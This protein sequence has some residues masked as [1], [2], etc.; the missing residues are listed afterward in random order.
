MYI[1]YKTCV[2][3]GDFVKYAMACFEAVGDKVKNWIMF[4]EPHGFLIEGCDMGLQAL[5]FG[6]TL[7]A[8]A[9]AGE[10]GV[11]FF[12]IFGSEFIKIFV[13]V[14]T[15]QVRDLFKK[16][17]ENAPCIIFIDKLDAVGRQRGA[18]IG[19]HND[20]IEQTLNQLLIEMDGFDRNTG[21]TVPDVNGRKA[22]LKVHAGN[23][24]L[25]KDVSLDVVAMRTPG[26]S[27][28][29]VAGME[30]TAMTDGKSKSLVAY[31]EVGHVIYVTFIPRHDPVK[32]VT[33]VPRGQAQGLT[34]FMPG[35]DPRKISK[36]QIFSRIVGSL[37][38]KAAEEIIFGEPKLKVKLVYCKELDK[39]LDQYSYF[40]V[41]K[42]R[43]LV[44]DVSDIILLD[45]TPLSIGLETLGGVM[46][47][48]IPRNTTL[49]TSKSEVF[50]TTANGQMSVEINVLQGEREFLKDNKSLGSFRLDRILPT[51]RG[52]P[53]IEVRFD[54]DANGIL[55]A[56]V[57]DK[58]TRKKQDITIIG[59][60][61]LSNDEVDRMLKELG[62]KVLAEVKV[63]V[64][65]KMKDLRDAML[66]EAV[67]GP[68]AGVEAGPANP[69]GKAT[70]SGE[71]IDADFIDN[72]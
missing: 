17:K 29:I 11:P 46:T 43:V 63:K 70:S 1:P 52:V 14:G 2:L 13:G 7:L 26:F 71:V 50:S 58:G 62:D 6:K 9:I 38:G 36:Q 40:S 65:A 18:G 55:L 59:A 67:G 30:G 47:K 66:P 10:A 60:S 68:T 5:E 53:Q 15:S 34:W 23:K 48:I 57:V 31:H 28:I 22:I 54:I 72:N 33:L 3:S 8:K 16:A 4:N 49:P 51:P 12:S 20:E 61:I 25:N 64:E 41:Q 24:K 27:D 37:G 45:V 39:Y 42:A 44:G 35:E 19:G 69:G 21:V 32:K 56:T